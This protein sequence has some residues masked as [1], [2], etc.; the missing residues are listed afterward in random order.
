MRSFHSFVLF[1]I[2]AAGILAIC[3]F[4]E[5]PVYSDILRQGSAASEKQEVAA[6]NAKAT[7]EE[8]EL[9]GLASKPS[10]IPTNSLALAI[11]EDPKQDISETIL[12]GSWVFD[13]K[14]VNRKGEELR[15]EFVFDEKGKG[16]ATLTDAAGH[17]Y[18]AKAQAEIKDGVLAIESDRYTSADSDIVYQESHILCAKGQPLAECRDRNGQWS[19][20]HLYAK[21]AQTAANLRKHMQAFEEKK[22]PS[23]AKQE[24]Q[25]EFLS[26]PDAPARPLAK[27]ASALVV[28]LGTQDTHHVAGKWGF[29][30]D[31][32]AP[33]NTP[34]H[35]EFL[36]GTDGQGHAKLTSSKHGVFDAKAN[37]VLEDN[38]VKIVTSRFTNADSG[39]TFP[40][41]F[42]ECRNV[43]D[44]AVCTGSDGWKVWKNEQLL[45]EN[46]AAVQSARGAKEHNR[47]ASRTPMTSEPQPVQN[48][49]EVAA[50]HFA[51]LSE[52]GAELPPQVMQQTQKAKYTSNSTSPLLGDWRYSRDFARKSD[53]GSVG[54]EF[55]FDKDGKGYSVIRQGGASDARANAESSVM[56]NGTIRVK[57]EAYSS[58]DGTQYYPT[59]MECRS[60]KNK[61]LNCD[62]SNGW[63]RLNNGTL[64]SLDGLKQKEKESVMEELMPSSP[65]AS[66]EQ[67]STEDLL[68]EMATPTQARTE[69]PQT[70][71]V[72]PKSESGMSFLKGKWRCNTGLVRTTDREPVIVEF[73]F[74]AN[75]R[76]TSTI[77]EKNGT[78]YSA[79]AKAVYKNG[80]LRINTSD[81]Y[82]PKQRGRYLGQFM[83]CRQ[84]DTRAL[85]NGRDRENNV[86]W[87]EA[88]FSRIH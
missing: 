36:F 81:F 64:L 2:V 70:A 40:A 6:E 15:N 34:V 61:E 53:G 69:S 67:K 9:I 47:K 57:T 14:L 8:G 29:D 12:D 71:L 24:V 59:F 7:Q 60:A 19:G 21:D 1:S 38:T 84:S 73:S 82:A 86:R 74:D 52:G 62:V 68:A 41:F 37:A 58:S 42:I 51:E 35:A 83:E 79:S 17:V 77:R 27:D 20:E 3:L 56:P 18:S 50:E 46:E 4:Q 44:S 33:D 72:L 65:Q 55:H 63:L 23:A 39:R 66:A 25:E 87:S 11:P 45:A 31:F 30:R 32:I 13:R 48:S 26:L 10:E 16:Q 49:G 88:T 22:Q 75:G 43:K 54:L 28:P 76:G 78:V 80:N 85:C 5:S